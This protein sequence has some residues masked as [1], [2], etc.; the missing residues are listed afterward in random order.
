MAEITSDRPG[1]G[2]RQL[3]IA[4]FAMLLVIPNA[5][6]LLVSGTTAEAASAPAAT[7]SRYMSTVDARTPENAN[8]A[9]TLYTEGCNA[10]GAYG[11]LTPQT[12][13]IVLN[14]GQPFYSGNSYGAYL[15]NNK[16]Q[17]ISAIMAAAEAWLLGYWD[18]SPTWPTINL[19][20]GT[21]NLNYSYA[22]PS[23]HGQAWAQMVN[24]IASWASPYNSQEAVSGA[25]DI[26]VQWASNSSTESWALAYT[27][28]H[29]HPYYDYGN[30]ICPQS[31]TT[32][33]SRQC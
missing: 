4:V 24:S 20:I 18:C 31:G 21:N 29:Q 12:G 13:A 30:A 5:V 26:E 7:T 15:F 1:P 11:T 22:D 28:Y 17:P 27:K 16:F 19:M 3:P 2:L 32:S 8:Y 10:G 6:G 25:N 9:G 33:T 14:F 23:G